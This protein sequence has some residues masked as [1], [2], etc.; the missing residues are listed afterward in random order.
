MAR[1]QP[2]E[3]AIAGDDDQ[4]RGVAL[5]GFM[6]VGKS[7][8]GRALAKR[9]VLPFIDLDDLL[10][11]R[12]GPIAHQ[13]AEVGEA[14]FRSRELAAVEEVCAGEPVVLATG[15]GTW[16]DARNRDRLRRRFHL[17]VL[18]APLALLAAR[19]EA[20]GRPLWD[21]DVGTRYAARRSAYA[22]AD[23][24]VDAAGSVE[25]I[26]EEIASWLR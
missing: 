7:T 22:D 17:V 9:L 15:G 8:V 4:V 21:D 2:D 11:E 14:G 1:S 12:H 10:T 25:Q 20:D 26:V 6:G 3:R 16:V 13:F 24:R 5:G 23:L 18:D 19:T